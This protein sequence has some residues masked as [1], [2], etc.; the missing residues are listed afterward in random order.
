MRPFIPALTPESGGDLIIGTACPRGRFIS[1]MPRFDSPRNGH[2]R[3][4]IRHP[5]TVDNPLQQI[6]PAFSIT[7]TR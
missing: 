5:P 2:S 1:A 3:P 6:D 4:F 7:S